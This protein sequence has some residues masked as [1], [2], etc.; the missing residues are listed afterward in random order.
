MEQEKPES[1]WTQATDLFNIRADCF[2]CDELLPEVAVRVLISALRLLL[3]LLAFTAHAPADA[4]ADC[5]LSARPIRQAAC[6]RIIAKGGAD[7]ATLAAVY[8]YR[9]LT[10]D[11][12]SEK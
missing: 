6:D 3:L 1:C 8:R 12:R 9:A 4:W 7:P 2:A 5:K 10:F 11:F